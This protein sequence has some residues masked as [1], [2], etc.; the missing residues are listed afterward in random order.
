MPS[1]RQ[2]LLKSW[3]AEE[4][5][6]FIGWDF[7]HLSERMIEEE[8]PWSYEAQA[9][10]LMHSAGA[11]LDMDTGGGERLLQLRPAWPARVAVT[12]AYPPNIDVARRNLEP[13]GVQVVSLPEDDS[14]AELPF[15]AGEFD[16][17]LNRHGYYVAT[18]LM[19]ILTPGGHFLTKQIHGLWAWDL[20]AAFDA[21]TQ[22]P[23]STAE[24][25]LA[26]LAEAGFD[27]VTVED[28]RGT[29]RFTDVGAIVYYLKA[30][31]WTVPGFGVESHQRYLFALQERL[32]AGGTLDFE[33]RTF[34]IQAQK[35]DW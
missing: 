22:Y 1:D 3:R 2:A 9:T 20:M 28:W 8:L 14:A 31:P 23:D 21:A 34:L 25:R 32:D 12:E 30:I 15:A 10:T 17:V 18:E 35:P 5:H 27:I 26:E 16:L 19:R 11:A 24:N 33:I 4:Q 13:H 6:P 29:M 7:S